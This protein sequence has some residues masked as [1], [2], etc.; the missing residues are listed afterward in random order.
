MEEEIIVDHLRF[1][2]FVI[3]S[4]LFPSYTLECNYNCGRMVNS[5]PPATCDGGCATPPP[6]PGFPPKYTPEIFEEVI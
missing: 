6:A 1:D 4:V 5:L 2:S 3:K